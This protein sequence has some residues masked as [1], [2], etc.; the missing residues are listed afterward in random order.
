MGS[1]HGPRLVAKCPCFRN[2]LFATLASLTTLEADSALG[3]LADNVGANTNRLKAVQ[4]YYIEPM[5][6]MNDSAE[7]PLLQIQLETRRPGLCRLSRS[8]EEGL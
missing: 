1:R 3:M 2:L 7:E 4:L 5:V 6:N 8:P